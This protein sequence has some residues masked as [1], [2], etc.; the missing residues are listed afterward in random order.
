MSNKTNVFSMK[1]AGDAIEKLK[2]EIAE[3]AKYINE[4]ETKLA[5][6]ERVINISYEAAFKYRLPRK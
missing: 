2:A 1:T 4:L 3:K 6:A 5:E